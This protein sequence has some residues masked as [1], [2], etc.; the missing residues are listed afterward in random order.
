M[1]NVIVLFLAALFIS[2]ASNAEPCRAYIQSMDQNMRCFLDVS[3]SAGKAGASL[4]KREPGASKYG[5]FN[6]SAEVLG[7]TAACTLYDANPKSP[8][9]NLFNKLTISH[10]S[11]AKSEVV[12]AW[13][14]HYG[15]ISY[16]PHPNLI[17]EVN[18]SQAE[19]GCSVY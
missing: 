17:L 19:L 14:Y 1:K 18:G 11:G 5:W 6:D 13:F 8:G 15:K 7:F 3:G 2:S 4:M 9:N 12:I 16:N 10:V